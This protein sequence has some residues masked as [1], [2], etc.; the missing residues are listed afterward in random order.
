MTSLNISP[1]ASRTTI[2][3]RNTLKQKYT[4]LTAL[5]AQINPHMLYNTLETIRWK[6]Y[7]LTDGYNEVVMMLET[8]SAL[9]KYS[10][11][12]AASMVSLGEEIDNTVNYIRLVKLRYPEQFQIVWQYSEDVMDYATMRLILQPVIENAIHHG[13]RQ[14]TGGTT[15]IKIRI[16][17]FRGMIKV[18]ILNTGAGMTP[19]QL[20]QVRS[21]LELDF[22]PA[23]GMGLFNI[24]KRLQLQYGTQLSIRSRPAHGTVVAFSFPAQRYEP[25]QPD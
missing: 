2:C 11:N 12:P 23:K 18:R 6:S 22:A 1:G 25:P 10:L 3:C 19:P 5:Q 8:L 17:R 7:A 9:L 14:S 20:A 21:T 4:E 24:N 13:A 15:Y 16:S